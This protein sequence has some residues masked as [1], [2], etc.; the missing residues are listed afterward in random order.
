MIINKLIKLIYINKQY[1]YIFNNKRAV[2][3]IYK[4]YSIIA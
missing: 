2:I 3:F 1:Y 4:H